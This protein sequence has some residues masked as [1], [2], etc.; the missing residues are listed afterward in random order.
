MA[1]FNP[2]SLLQKLAG[3]VS[4]ESLGGF[5]GTLQLELTG[6]KNGTWHV[7]IENKQYDV[8]EGAAENP[9]LTLTCDS[10][11]FNSL[12]AGQLDIMKSFMTGRLRISGDMA[13]A[14]RLA[15]SIR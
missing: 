7:V 11:D 1:E 13:M 14:M 6:E 9:T 10:T 2:E 15:G 3:K 5:S 8:C 12:L 4:A